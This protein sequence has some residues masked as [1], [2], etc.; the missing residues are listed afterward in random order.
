MQSCLRAIKYYS[1]QK[2]TGRLNFQSP[3]NQKWSIYYRLGRIAWAASS[4]NPNRRL[5]RHLYHSVHNKIALKDINLSQTELEEPWEYQIITV[6]SK[7]Q[8]LSQEQ[9]FSL[10]EGA[11][12]EI[13]FDLIQQAATEQLNF[14]YELYNFFSPTL[15]LLNTD[16]CL[17]QVKR[18]W[19][20]WH[21]QGLSEF[22]PNLAPIISQEQKLKEQ[23][24]KKVYKNLK[25]L[26]NGKR[27]LRELAVLMKKDLIPLT[28][29]L[30]PYYYQGIIDLVKVPDWHL[31][32]FPLFNAVLESQSPSKPEKPLIACIDDSAQICQV[33]QQIVTEAGYKFIGIQDPLQA[34]TIL[35]RRKP[36]LIFLDLIMPVINGYELCSQMRRI[37]SFKKTPIII[38][39]SHD[40][41]VERVRARISEATGFLSKPIKPRHVTAILQKHI[42]APK[43]N[44]SERE[45]RKHQASTN[46]LTQPFS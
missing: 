13:L 28:K 3:S 46:S 7:Q 26:V 29:S 18:E 27:T 36:D 15:I 23:T 25:T 32:A 11:V 20:A 16:Q 6:L 24:S 45:M 41:I 9:I 5:L 38:L 10:V 35:M 1:D 34:L 17:E 2:I 39:T 43:Q 37:S 44:Q 40:G 21:A 14:K 8:R 33:M 19:S 12:N 31:S 30:I 22:S 4:I 42:P